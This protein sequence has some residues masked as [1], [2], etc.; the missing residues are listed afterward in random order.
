M[1]A[2]VDDKIH[3]W[4]V[5]NKDQFTVNIELHFNKEN[6]MKF[7]SHMESGTVQIKG[8]WE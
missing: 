6:L 7:L 5:D 4:M 2:K 1:K 3:K 8:A